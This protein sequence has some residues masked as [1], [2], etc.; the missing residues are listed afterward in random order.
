M[1]KELDPSASPQDDMGVQD[2]MLP[3]DDM[4]NPP[5]MLSVSEASI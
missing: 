4:L 3:Q 5:V 1:T 2:D